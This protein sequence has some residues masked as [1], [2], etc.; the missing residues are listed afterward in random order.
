MPSKTLIAAVSLALGS[1]GLA[2]A[3]DPGREDV[4]IVRALPL[5]RSVLE[6]VQPV[7]VL[8]GDRLDDRRG[9]TLG[10]TLQHELGVHTTYYG[11]G[12]G[13]P[14]IRGLGGPRVRIL[15]DG[16]S[17]GDLAAQ[18]DDHLVTVDPLLIRQ[19]EILRGPA[20][21]LY[22]SGASG[23]VV[24]VIDDRIPERLPDGPFE[25]GVVLRAD[26]VADERSGAL[27][28]DGAFGS[29]AW[30][31]D[32]TWRQTDDYRIPSAA[33][34]DRDVDHDHDHD[35]DDDDDDD[36]GGNQRLVNS[37]VENLGGTLGGSWIGDRGFVGASFRRFNSEYGIPAPHA[38][39]DDH[40]DDHDDVHDQDQGEAAE[41]GDEFVY[42]DARQRRWDMKAGLLDPIRGL[43]RATFHLSHTDYAHAERPFTH[44]VDHDHDHASDDGLETRFRLRTLQSRIQFEHAPIGEWRGAFGLQLEQERFSATGEDVVTPDGRTRSAGL[45]VVEERVWGPL[46]VNVGGRVEA[47]R[48]RA[49]ELLGEYDDR[50]HDLDHDHGHD[51]DDDHEDVTRNF[52]VWS[53]SIGG[54]W[55][56]DERWQ[57]A[58]NLSRA[59]RAPSH[60]ELFA[61]GPHAAT[62]SFE[63]GEPDLRRETTHGWDVG[64]RY[65]TPRLG[66]ELNL[67]HN[68]VKDFV[69]LQETGETLAGLPLR[70]TRQANTRLHGFETRGTWQIPDTPAGNFEVWA[71]YDQVRGRLNGGGSLPR[72]SPQR[73]GLGLDWRNGGSLRG[74]LDWYRVFSQ[75]HVAAFETPTGGYHLL[76]ARVSYTFDFGG[77]GME[78]FLRAEN[79]TNEEAR[80]HTSFLKDYAPLPGRNL[81]FGLR[82]RF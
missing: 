17:T 75:D 5:D 26:S 66:L 19:I 16:L 3:Q 73:L 20:T 35:H 15:E 60:T 63:I 36:H 64:V 18:S 68:D 56:V 9:V 46:S 50:G 7:D 37:W 13:R 6:A 53:A 52:T 59:Q 32:G 81:I 54:I 30:H 77:R 49:D 11:P 40:D 70:L 22:G 78:A 47:T 61:F 27:H 41:L 44:E 76:G 4:I 23:G 25:G 33:R 29:F 28:F 2:L 45:F 8:S 58:L 48:I 82:G 43:D 72:M 24:N 38:H 55:H 1:S 62:F 74:G 67:F 57:V 71:S 31:A 39:D 10:E 51:I 12:S 65:D 21:L 42:A 79:L 34:V 80:V 69:F 14:I